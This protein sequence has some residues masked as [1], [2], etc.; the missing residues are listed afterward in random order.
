MSNQQLK[1]KS[2]EWKSERI[3]LGTLLKIAMLSTLF[4]KYYHMKIMLCIVKKNGV[5]CTI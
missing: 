5:M 4:K 1:N 2:K 3:V